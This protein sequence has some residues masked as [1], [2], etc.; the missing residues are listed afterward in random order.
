MKTGLVAIIL[1]STVNLYADGLK[2]RPETVDDAIAIGYGVATA[3]VDGDG[4]TDILL[5]DKRQYVWYRNPTWEKFVLAENL[6]KRDNVC[7]AAQD[8][9]G[10]GKCEIAVGGDWDPNDRENSGEIFYLV[11][12]EDRSQK[13][14]PIKLPAEP[15]VHRMRWMP[16][17]GSQTGDRQPWA[18][19]RSRRSDLRA[20]ATEPLRRYTPSPAVPRP[21]VTRAASPRDS[22]EPGP[23]CR[24]PSRTST[25]PGVVPP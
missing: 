18:T 5:A 9:D 25:V 10:D 6:T 21:S 19:G 24:R 15:T 22:A 2:F 3:D 12:P 4:K 11:P 7:I 16:F 20:A 1:C 8:I 17:S 13:W 14:E 23:E